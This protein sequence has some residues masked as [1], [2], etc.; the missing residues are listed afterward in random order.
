MLPA[1]NIQLSLEMNKNILVKYQSTVN[2]TSIYTMSILNYI[3]TMP[4]WELNFIS[5]ALTAYM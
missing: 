2:A 3:Y 5:C 1:D 4:V